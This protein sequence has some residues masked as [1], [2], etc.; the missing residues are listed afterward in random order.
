MQLRFFD[1]SGL[2]VVAGVRHT[3]DTRGNEW[4]TEITGVV[5]NWDKIRKALS[6]P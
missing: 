6:L 1:P 3:G 2:Y 4:Y 5:R